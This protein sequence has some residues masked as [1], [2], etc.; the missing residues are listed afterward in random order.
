M[1]V[2]VLVKL[3]RSN[4]SYNEFPK[5]GVVQVHC[6]HVEACEGDP[7]I[8]SNWKHVATSVLCSKTEIK[9]LTPGTLYWFRVKAVGAKG[10]GPGHRMFRSWQYNRPQPGLHRC[11]I[12][13]DLLPSNPTGTFPKLSCR[14]SS[15]RSPQLSIAGS[16]STD[17]A[18]LADSLKKP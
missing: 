3:D 8:E 1:E 11:K 13:G 14:L 16:T 18:I 15:V 6:Y 17:F 10:F 7:S 12:D 5:P 2:Q 9:G 4:Y